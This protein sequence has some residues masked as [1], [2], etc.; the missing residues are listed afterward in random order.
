[1]E[2]AGTMLDAG[3]EEEAPPSE[4]WELCAGG[5]TIEDRPFIKPS[6]GTGIFFWLTPGTGMLEYES[7]KMSS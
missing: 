3:T 2:D 6:T 5:A 1:M 7:A 4:A